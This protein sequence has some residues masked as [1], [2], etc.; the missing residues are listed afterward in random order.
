MRESARERKS[1]RARER[2]SE[3]ERSISEAAMR[4]KKQTAFHFSKICG[5]K[6]CWLKKII[7]ADNELNVHFP[8]SK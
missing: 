2:E 6:S 8:V 3:K 4:K 1:E 7:D 5:S